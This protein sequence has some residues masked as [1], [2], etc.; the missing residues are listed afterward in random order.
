MSSH[1]YQVHKVSFYKD[2]CHVYN[3]VKFVAALADIF[4]SRRLRDFL[5]KIYFLSLRE[6]VYSY[7]YSV[8]I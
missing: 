5:I 4:C 8:K 3:L 2:C 6:I 7:I 1:D